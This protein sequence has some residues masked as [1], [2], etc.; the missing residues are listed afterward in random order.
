MKKESIIYIEVPGIKNLENSYEQD[1][2]KYLQ[3]A[4]VYH[5]TLNTLKN[6][7][8]KAGLRCFNGNEIINSIF[9]AGE[10]DNNFNN[11]FDDTIN[12]LE[13]LEKARINP[14]NK[15]RMKKKFLPKVVDFLEKTNTKEIVKKAYK[16]SKN[17]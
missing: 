15:F 13:K 2:L 12:Y 6:C 14:L 3:N 7:C 8:S 11:N 17:Q 5:F 16:K 9:V 4:H 1:F 10:E